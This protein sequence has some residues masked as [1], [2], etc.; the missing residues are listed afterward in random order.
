MAG[1]WRREYRLFGYDARVRILGI[2]AEAESQ[3]T[4]AES[5]AR[6]LA[7]SA[8]GCR[9]ASGGRSRKDREAAIFRLELL[10]AESGDWICWN[11]R[12]FVRRSP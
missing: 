11:C 6:T 3:G 8:L 9:S 4:Q 12:L 7:S 2:H 1:T 5:S 10:R